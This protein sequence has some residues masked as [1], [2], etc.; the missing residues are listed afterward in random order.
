MDASPRIALYP[1]SFDP[2]TVGHVDVVK[3]ALRLADQVVVAV[4]YAPTHSKTELFTVG[5]RVEMIRQSFSD[6]PR[7]E[8]M[9]FQGLLVELARRAGARLVVRGVRTVAD[10]EYEAQMSAMN[11]RLAPEVETVFL[12][13]DPE[14]AFVSATLVRQVAALGGDASPFVPVPVLRALRARFP[15]VR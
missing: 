13:P 11:R 3:R 9:E 8:V 4:S 2:L 10:F 7:V 12:A 6:E 15:L 5:E 14:H 1:G